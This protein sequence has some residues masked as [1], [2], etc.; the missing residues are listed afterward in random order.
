[1]RVTTELQTASIR[2]SRYCC[3]AGPGAKAFTEMHE[4]HP[5]SYVRRGSF[6]YRAHGQA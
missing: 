2:V 3:D 6:G 1:M 4:G 5:V